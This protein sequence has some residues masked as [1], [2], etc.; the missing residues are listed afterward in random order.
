MKTRVKELEQFLLKCNMQ[1]HLTVLTKEGYFLEYLCDMND[2]QFYYL[3]ISNDD[4]DIIREALKKVKEVAPSVVVEQVAPLA[5]VQRFP[6]P[7]YDR[8]PILWELKSR[9]F[10]A[11]YMR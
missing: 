9:D 6:Y 7:L 5:V 2:V 8:E 11:K 3:G 10:F 4:R 1:K